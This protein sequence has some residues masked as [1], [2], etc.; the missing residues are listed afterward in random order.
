MG[1]AKGKLSLYEVGFRTPIILNWPGQIPVGVRD[2]FV[3]VEDLFP[4]LLNYAGA[5]PLPDRRGID[6]R[7]L[8]ESGD[9]VPRDALLGAMEGMRDGP[10]G[11]ELYS[12]DDDLP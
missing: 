5:S 1:G 11:R 12:V 9:P 7:P 3:S 2:D 4:T 8:L 6:L 10:H